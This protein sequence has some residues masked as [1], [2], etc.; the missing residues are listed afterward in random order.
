M[1]PDFEVES[2]VLLRDYKDPGVDADSGLDTD[3]T[4]HQTC[5]SLKSEKQKLGCWY[6][7]ALAEH[8]SF[9][10]MH[11]SRIA[12]NIVYKDQQRTQKLQAAEKAYSEVHMRTGHWH[13][14]KKMLRNLAVKTQILIHLFSRD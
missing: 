10:E 9:L 4:A 8:A 7:L 2:S 11:P 1:W 14:S 3:E 12:G 5:M 13:T 6:T